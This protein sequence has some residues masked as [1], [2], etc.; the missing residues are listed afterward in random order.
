[1]IA[2]EVAPEWET[3]LRPAHPALAP[4]VPRG[5]VGYAERSAPLRRLEVPH[6]AIV[7]ILNLGPA[8]AV[9]DAVH[10]SFVAGLHDRA[11]VTPARWSTSWP[12]RR[13]G[14][15]ASTCSTR[16]C[17]RLERAAPP[18]PD[19]AFAWSRLVASHGAM[20]V[21]DLSPSWAAAAATSP[22]GATAAAERQG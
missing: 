21:G 12:T 16:S 15:R 11:V 18:R 4:Y 10:R 9:G 14:R 17:S 6:H 20:A 5:Y 19:V 2:H 1:V 13:A 22:R 3:A 8:L 7:V